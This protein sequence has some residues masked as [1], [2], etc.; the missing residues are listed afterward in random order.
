METQLHLNHIDELIALIKFKDNSKSYFTQKTLQ[1]FEL[2]FILCLEI[3]RYEI[4]T[5]QKISN[6][7]AA[8]ISE[9]FAFDAFQFYYRDYPEIHKMCSLVFYELNDFNEDLRNHDLDEEIHN[10]PE[11]WVDFFSKSIAEIIG[12]GE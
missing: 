10:T 6:R 3:I 1:I 7:N 8:A 4:Q 11:F 2:R 5:Q 12:P 9:L